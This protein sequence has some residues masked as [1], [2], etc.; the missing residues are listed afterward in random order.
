MKNLETE[1]FYTKSLSYLK[2]LCEEIPERWVGSEGNRMATQFFKN[3]IASFGWDIETQAFNGEDYYGASGQMVYISKNQNKFHDILLNI[4]IDGAGFINGKTVFSFFHLPD[5]IKI[6]LIDNL[7]NQQI[8]HTA[9]DNVEI[10]DCQK[11]V[12]I[13]EVLNKLI[14]QL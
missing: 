5:E 3:E 12:V 8:T 9:N 7:E 1:K 13:S 14:R 6:W 10:V 11:I 2:T 4:T